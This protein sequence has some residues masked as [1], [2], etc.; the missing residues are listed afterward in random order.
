M[1]TAISKILS[2]FGEDNVYSAKKRYLFLV[3]FV[4]MAIFE[5]ASLKLSNLAPELQ[6]TIIPL[7]I[8]TATFLGFV[9]LIAP[10]IFY[11]AGIKNLYVYALTINLSMSLL[12][13][14]W[15]SKGNQTVFQ[16]VYGFIISSVF[17]IFTLWV[18]L[19]L[20]KRKSPNQKLQPTV[21][22]PVE[23]GNEQGTAAEL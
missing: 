15:F 10:K 3:P 23:S 9:T 17:Y 21:T 7:T 18:V 11:A 22:T 2:F 4:F 14:F 5:F 8:L 1:N 19:F 12:V 16:C 13:Y 20:S 6:R